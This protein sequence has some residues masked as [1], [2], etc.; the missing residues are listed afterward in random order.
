M[1]KP[2][3]DAYRDRRHAGAVLA[4]ALSER[5]QTVPLLLALPRGGVMVASEMARRLEAELDVLVVRKVGVPGQEELAMGA[6][7]S[8]GIHVINER[9]ARQAGID[10]RQREALISGQQRAVEERDRRYRGGMPAPDL[11]DRCVCLVDDGL[12]TGASMTAAVQVVHRQGPSQI[13]VAVPVA[14]REMRR[15][16]EKAVDA[17]VC[18]RE[19][20]RF[21]S[22]GQWY[23]D[24]S[25]VT[26]D[27]VCEI[28]RES[29]R[30]R[31]QPGRAGS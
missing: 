1:Q 28:L 11:A 12:A 29:E 14:P 17:F 16:F 15:V 23:E 26:D 8:G 2:A 7:A 27:Q 19:P 9:I 21:M 31:L 6:V 3:N 18:P 13:I 22:V 5:V 4:D 25:E 10:E 20:E 24:F 30:S